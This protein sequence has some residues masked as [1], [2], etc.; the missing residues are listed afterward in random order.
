MSVNYELA[1]LFFK[2]HVQRVR[3][4]AAMLRETDGT[5]TLRNDAR[6]FILTYEQICSA[7]QPSITAEDL[8]Q[9][10]LAKLPQ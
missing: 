6:S 8:V 10:F 4:E 2:L 3:S 7:I 9:S 5:A 1:D